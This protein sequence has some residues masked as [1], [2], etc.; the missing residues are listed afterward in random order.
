MP[1]I[2]RVGAGAVRFHKLDRQFIISRE[3]KQYGTQIYNCE[4]DNGWRDDWV[5]DGQLIFLFSVPH[6]N[7]C[8][9]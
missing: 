3:Q 1:P 6:L 8:Y 5:F 9:L 7:L 2:Y 4:R